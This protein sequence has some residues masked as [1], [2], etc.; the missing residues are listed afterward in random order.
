MEYQL[1]IQ[2]PA[3][4]LKDFDKLVSIEDMLIAGLGDL[5]LVDGHDMGSGEANL[6][7]LGNDPQAIFKKV[8]EILD[9]KKKTS[10]MKA[11]FRKITE[12]NYK[13]IWPVG[14]ASFSVK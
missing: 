14:L 11:G 7:I 3:A 6:F 10:K 5:A 13:P 4:D 9:S 1:V 2:F 8:K 12:E